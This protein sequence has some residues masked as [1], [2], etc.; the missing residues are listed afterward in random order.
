MKLSEYIQTGEVGK[1]KV[2]VVSGG[3]FNKRVAVSTKIGIVELSLIRPLNSS[4]FRLKNTF[5]KAG[6][7]NVDEIITE[8]TNIFGKNFIDI[9][10]DKAIAS[11][12]PVP[13]TI[14]NRLI[15]LRADINTFY[16]IR[17]TKE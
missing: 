8:L 17:Y 11:I 15:V 2:V 12:G 10:W 3:R 5:D 4:A 9:K 13:D 16:G 6:L 7:K 1:D 14:F